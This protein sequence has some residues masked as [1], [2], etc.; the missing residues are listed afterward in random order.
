MNPSFRK[1]RILVTGAAG[2]IGSN[3][4]MILSAQGHEVIGVD[5]FMKYPKDIRPQFADFDLREADLCGPDLMRVLGN[6]Y[7][8]AYHLAAVVGVEKVCKEPKLT[9]RNN[10]LSTIGF[11]EWASEAV[12][13]RV[14]FASSCEN[15]APFFESDQ[16]PI[17]TPEDVFIGIKEIQ[18]PRWT[19]STSKIWGEVAFAQW[20]IPFT[21]VRY[22]NVYGPAM[23]SRHVIPE[24][25]SK[26]WQGV[27]PL[28]VVSAAHTRAFC[29]VRDAVAG[30]IATM[31]GA[32][33]L[34]QVV[35]VGSDGCEIS[36]GDLARMMV[37]VSGRQIIVEDQPG[38]SGSVSRRAPDISRLHGLMGDYNFTQ[39]E[40]GLRECWEWQER[41]KWIA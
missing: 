12:S 17:P 21:V 9:L 11:L 14:L 38:L 15:Y 1:K 20:G 3:L 36:M 10:T 16:L 34:G 13:Q 26:I 2:F 8:E 29:H 6:G 41:A 32:G 18:H 30:T 23:N 5:N 40:E 28:K 19:Y 22:H 31:E 33:S 7:D 39:L 24:I 4:A 27:N 25:F 37:K 35:N